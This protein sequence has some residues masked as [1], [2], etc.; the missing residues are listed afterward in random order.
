MRRLTVC[1]AG[2]AALAAASCMTMP[3]DEPFLTATDDDFRLEKRTRYV[4][5]PGNDV[6]YYAI[7]VW[8]INR[9]AWTYCVTRK[10]STTGREGA[11]S[12][13][14]GTT[15]RLWNYSASSFDDEWLIRRMTG[16]SCQVARVMSA[17]P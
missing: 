12:V 1:V 5:H 13:A 11:Y 15:E 14:P 2:L 17:S 9:S 4:G 7:E 16:A 6:S 10:I 3:A 8:A